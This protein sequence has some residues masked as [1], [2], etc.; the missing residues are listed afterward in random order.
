MVLVWRPVGRT[1]I[2]IH[3]GGRC[4]CMDRRVA[5]ASSLVAAALAVAIVAVDL[6]YNVT[7]SLQTQEDDGWTTVARQDEGSFG[8]RHPYFGCAGPEM[9][10]LIDNDLPWAQSFDVQV[11]VHRFDTG[12]DERLLDETVTVGGGDQEHIPFTVPEWA[13]SGNAS[14]GIKPLGDIEVRVDDIFLSSCVEAPA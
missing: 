14:D 2:L 8:P 5:L 13:W 4:H 12:Q 6:Q 11:D 7:V 9:R 3:V 1:S 10:I